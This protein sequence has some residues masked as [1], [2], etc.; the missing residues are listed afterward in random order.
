MTLETDIVGR[1]V[2]YLHPILTSFQSTDLIYL[3]APMSI[4]P[5]VLLEAHLCRN[6]N[7]PRDQQVI[8]GSDERKDFLGSDGGRR[9]YIG[10]TAVLD[11]LYPGREY[12]ISVYW[13][14]TPLGM[15]SIRK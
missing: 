2:A 14:G 11:N 7:E 6:C 12:I 1:R 10:T 15:E 4:A 8:L 9:S 13:Q 5:R 3:N